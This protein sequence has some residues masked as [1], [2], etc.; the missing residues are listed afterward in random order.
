M[1]K[2]IYNKIIPF[3]GYM[4]ITIWPL[5]FARVRKL[6][7]SALNHERIHL[8]QQLEVVLV[9]AAILLFIVLWFEL[10]WWWMLLSMAMYYIG[11]GIGFAIRYLVYRSASEA[12]RN[13]ATE[14]EAYLNQYDET[15]LNR[16]KPFAW[17]RYI[18]KKTY[19]RK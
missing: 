9:S 18:G 16:R 10:S 8:R 19:R 3:K 4:A 5:I 14:Q 15:Y 17:V 1:A 2:V 11:Y 12:G 13:I 6:R 7:G